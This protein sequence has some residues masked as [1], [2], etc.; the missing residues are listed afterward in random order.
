MTSSTVWR[1]SLPGATFETAAS[2]LGSRRGSSSEGDRVKPSS[3][4]AQSGLVSLLSFD[5]LFGIESGANRLAD[6]LGVR[7]LKCAMTGRAF[8]GH[9]PGEAE[10][11]AFLQPAVRLRRTAPTAPSP[12][13]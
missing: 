2:R 4:A 9:D 7:H 10:L 11:R 13:L 3:A 1:S 12:R 8:R 6:G 5:G